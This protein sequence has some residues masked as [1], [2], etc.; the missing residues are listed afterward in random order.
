MANKGPTVDVTLS[1]KLTGSGLKEG[2][3]QLDAVDDAA[4]GA[5][6][7]MSTMEDEVRTLETALKALDPATD[8]FQHTAEKLGKVR[9][10]LQQTADRADDFARKSGGAVAPTRNLGGAALELSRAFEDAQYGIG[11]V[12]NNLPGLVAMAGGTAGAA[13]VVSL[14]AVAA[15][16]LAKNLGKAE[17]EAGK[18]E[19][20]EKLDELLRDLTKSFKDLEEGRKS[21][22]QKGLASAF[23]A[24]A[25]QLERET[26]AIIA[27]IE[28]L[29]Q[30]EIIAG[31]IRSAEGRRDLATLAGQEQRGEVTPEDAAKKRAEIEVRMANEEL[32]QL[33]TVGKL[34]LQ[35]F[36]AKT[37]AARD[38]L[39]AAMRAQQAAAGQLEQQAALEMRFK[40]LKAAA[41]AMKQLQDLQAA[42]GRDADYPLEPFQDIAERRRKMDALGP[43]VEAVGFDAKFGANP[44]TLERVVKEL[45]KVKLAL[46][47]LPDDLGGLDEKVDAAKQKLREAQQNLEVATES[48]SGEK[49]VRDTQQQTAGIEATN[50]ALEDKAEAGGQKIAELFEKWVESLGAAAEKEEPAALIERVRTMFEGGVSSSEAAAIPLLAQQ[51]AAAVNK[52]TVESRAAFG[53][54]L[55]TVETQAAE[56]SKIKAEVAALKEAIKADAKEKK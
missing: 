50:A 25:A 54:L 1:T 28:Q 8:E 5:A 34:N 15:N 22:A 39:A 38:E 20:L 47:S 44:G 37:I 52:V 51:I 35:V 2:E 18:K 41:E 45:E 21:A 19:N 48:E 33:D 16:M 40:E 17:E 6:R 9:L 26:A 11:G 53:S 14:L 27:N 4:K 12:I 10:E 36:E 32:H 31:K 43:A 24:E 30:R 49:Q 42:G 46:D 23:E 7:S 56:L 13:A 29:K 55:S 3:K